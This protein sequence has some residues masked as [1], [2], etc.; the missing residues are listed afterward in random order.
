M[1]FDLLYGVFL[2]LIVPQLCLALSIARD[3]LPGWMQC[4]PFFAIAVVGMLTSLSPPSQLVS[5]IFIIEM[6]RSGI[7]YAAHQLK[8]EREASVVI[9]ANLDPAPQLKKEREGN[10][11]PAVIDANLDPAPQLH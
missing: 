10:L 2:G 5:L 3:E 9:N 7:T 8:K 11:Q 1:L 4:W 6:V